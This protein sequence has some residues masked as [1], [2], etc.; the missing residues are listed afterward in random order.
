[1]PGVLWVSV[2]REIGEKVRAGSSGDSSGTVSFIGLKLGDCNSARDGAGGGCDR[3]SYV[4]SG[5]D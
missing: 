1:M 2:S 4:G 3:G 5:S